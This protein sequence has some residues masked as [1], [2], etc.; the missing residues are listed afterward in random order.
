M[1]IT[2]DCTMCLVVSGAQ[3]VIQNPKTSKPQA[4]MPQWATML[5]LSQC[6]RVNHASEMLWGSRA[7]VLS[8]VCLLFVETTHMWGASIGGALC[9]L[10]RVELLSPRVTSLLNQCAGLVWFGC[11]FSFECLFGARMGIAPVGHDDV[12]WSWCVSVWLNRNALYYRRPPC[13]CLGG[14]GVDMVFRLFN[15]CASML[16][17]VPSLV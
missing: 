5:S 11:P 8:R 15:R 4:S 16:V 14:G 10:Y 9:K 12:M 2:Q 13:V 7:T 3:Y 17:Y 6:G 1:L